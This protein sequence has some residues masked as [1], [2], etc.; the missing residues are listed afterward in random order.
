VHAGTGDGFTGTA[1]AVFGANLDLA[2]PA[3]QEAGPYAGFLN[4]TSVN[5]LP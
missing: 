3:G 4:I 1:G 5:A 2:I